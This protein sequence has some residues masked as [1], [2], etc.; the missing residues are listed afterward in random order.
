[1]ND[2]VMQA[3]NSVGTFTLDI[4]VTVVADV[5]IPSLSINGGLTYTLPNMTPV[6]GTPFAY[7]LA[8]NN[9]FDITGGT[10][11]QY[12]FAGTPFSFQFT[13][14]SNTS[15]TTYA[16]VSGP[17]GMT[18]D[19][20]TDLGTWT[21]TL[22]Q[23]GPTSITVQ[24]SNSAGTSTLTFN[25][26]TYFTTA[27]TSVAVN[28]YTSTS[29]TG[30]FPPDFTPVVSWTAPPDNG[31]AGYYVTVTDAH[32]QVATTYDTHSTNTSFALT[33]VSY[34]QNFV[35]VAAYDANGNPGITSNVASLYINA[36]SPI[37]WTFSTP[38]AVAGVPLSVQFHPSS[39]YYTYA[40]ASSPA[41]VTIN[42]ATGLLSWTPG[43]ADVGTANVVVAATNGWGTTFVTL[44]FPVYFTNA[45][46]AVS[47]L[48]S[49]D[50][51][52][53]TT[54]TATWASPT[55]N[56]GS[57]TGYQITFSDASAPAN[58]PPTIFTVT[59]DNLSV[60]LSNL[61]TLHGSVQ[62]AALDAA[63]DLGV[64]SPLFTF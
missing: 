38:N 15:P 58:A 1:V 33:G 44:N 55:M 32:T 40:I 10:H 45:P 2:I 19:S 24:A 49:T 54:W 30:S 16:L 42:S 21:P 14:T 11:P 28:F 52:G 31:I 57:I 48:S 9:G 53:G 7:Q 12:A 59:A 41:G 6:D 26:P 60:V 18:L 25:F 27:P 62:V 46:T 51:N 20:N 5:P 47:V 39:P 36:L 23:A 35:T 63:G 8:V 4:S 37:S 13:G 43:L 3:V 64:S 17:A 56:T 34:N 29:S 50:G 22:A 61:A